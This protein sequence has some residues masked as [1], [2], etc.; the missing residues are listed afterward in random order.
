MHMGVKQVLLRSK[1]KHK[2]E[3]LPPGAP[4]AKKKFRRENRLRLQC[5]P[6]HFHPATAPLIF[7]EKLFKQTEPLLLVLRELP[8]AITFEDV[9][10]LLPWN[11]R[12]P[13]ISPVSRAG[14]LVVHGPLTWES[15]PPMGFVETLRSIVIVL[16]R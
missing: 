5:F 15:I 2:R 9:E 1:C 11:M 7:P 16:F 3:R 14:L 4:S 12:L 6:E 10:A 13:D 8:T